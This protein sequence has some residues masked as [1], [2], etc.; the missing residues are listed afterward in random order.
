M[1]SIKSIIFFS[2]V[3]ILVLISSFPAAY[4][5][6]HY[7]SNNNTSNSTGIMMGNT[8]TSSNVVEII[9][10]QHL[11]EVDHLINEGYLTVTETIIFRNVGTQNYTGPIYTWLQDDAFNL[12]VSKN[13]MAMDSQGI[14]ITSFQVDD[15]IIGWND[16]IQS[17]MGMPSMYHL[18]YMIP[19][20]PNKEKMG[21]VDFIK[22]ITVPATVNY[23][24]VPMTGMY[25][26]VINT[27][28]PENTGI[29]ITDCDGVEIEPDFVEEGVNNMK[30]YNWV[31]PSFTRIC[32]EISQSKS[33]GSST[34][35]YAGIILV[36]IG[37]V[38]YFLLKGNG[39]KEENVEYEDED[40]GGYEDKDAS[41]YNDEEEVLTKKDIENNSLNELR[42]A[43]KAVSRVLRELDDDYSSG[44]ISEDEYD[45]IRSN[46]KKKAVDIAKRI[47]MLEKEQ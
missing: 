40:A 11:I 34:I 2:T 47:E 23:N 26:L 41:K 33:G 18:E 29:T 8:S 5:F 37:V 4:A 35:L 7:A 13:K 38:G 46:Y 43:K 27:I 10:V 42:A 12:V 19:V 21:S 6:A 28:Q 44:I 36:I 39:Q 20:D 1:S 17:S 25:A 14:A 16:S 45:T 24:Y 30:K 9:I 15:N 3:L 32:I 22:E 31:S